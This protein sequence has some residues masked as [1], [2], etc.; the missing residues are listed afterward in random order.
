MARPTEVTRSDDAVPPGPSTAPVD[1][2][3]GE[4]D[5][6]RP[7]RRLSP[8]L[9]RWLTLACFLVSAFVLRQ[10]FSPLRQGGQ[11][12]PM[13][14]LAGVLPMVFLCYRAGR[15]TGRRTSRITTAEDGTPPERDRRR[16]DPGVL[17]WALAVVAFVVCI[18]P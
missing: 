11:F 16:D 10:V 6:E 18:Y 17:D 15:R 2:I 1:E 8:G 14:F 13:L 3:V 9:D 7:G 4:F 12:Y 5:E